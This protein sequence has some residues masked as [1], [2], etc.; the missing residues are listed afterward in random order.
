MPY[1][2]TLLGVALY[3][4]M[5]AQMKGAS[6]AIGAYSAL[7]CRG[8]VGVAVVAPLWALT[9]GKWPA[10]PILRLHLLRGVV[11][12]GMALTFFFGLTRLPMAE[13]IAISF[14]APLI[15]LFLAA[16]MLGET[17]QRGAIFASLLG[18]AGVAVIGGGR[19]QASIPGDGAA[20]GIA[21]VL[22]S[23]LLYAWNLILQRRQ[24]QLAGP[25]EVALFMNGVVAL[26]LLPAAPFVAQWPETA[27][28]GG[29]IVA[30]ALLA[31]IAVMLFS[32]GY[33]RAE[34]QALVPLEYSAFIWAALMGW[35]MFG[36][37]LTLPT[38]AGTALVIAACWIAAPRKRT[39]QTSV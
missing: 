19:M 25:L 30:S 20:L 38:L 23:A 28:V 24:S 1:L 12:A 2:A 9:G 27:E 21:S 6:L 32:W 36:E 34:A 29:R 15:A 4:V 22:V 31:I 35:L 3:S 11:S 8:I 26:L 18:L 37:R 13:G 17:I 10:W 39:E 33:A 5:D 7:L 16:L 14:F